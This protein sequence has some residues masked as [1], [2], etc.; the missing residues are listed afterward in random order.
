MNGDRYNTKSFR[1]ISKYD[2]L[3]A[4]WSL[5]QNIILS[6]LSLSGT[7]LPKQISFYIWCLYISDRE[8]HL[9]VSNES[10]V[11]LFLNWNDKVQYM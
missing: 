3:Q 10:L 7:E 1:I 11:V 2:C 9:K 5:T 8:M 4:E 6:L